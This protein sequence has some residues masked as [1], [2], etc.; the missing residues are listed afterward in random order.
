MNIE[1]RLSNIEKRLDSLQESF[2]QAQK[3][4]VI[5]TSHAD[6]GNAVAPQVITNTSDILDNSDAIFELA[7]LVAEME[8]QNG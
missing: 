1:Q 3:N 7:E 5:V 2:I 8:A 6:T 4:N